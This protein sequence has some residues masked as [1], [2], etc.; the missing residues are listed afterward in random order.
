[1]T[2]PD[3]SKLVDKNGVPYELEGRFSTGDSKWDITGFRWYNGSWDVLNNHGLPYEASECIYIP[4]KRTL[5]EIKKSM[6]FA[7]DDVLN[8]ID[9]AYKL[10]LGKSKRNE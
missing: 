2:K 9:E 4:Q 10:G 7:S 5:E 8:A 3:I 1:M 6:C